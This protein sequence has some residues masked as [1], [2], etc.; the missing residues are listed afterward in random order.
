M[1]A[2][3]CALSM[4][5]LALP[6][7]GQGLNFQEDYDGQAVNT[8]PGA[9]WAIDPHMVDGGVWVD[10]AGRQRSAPY[11]LLINRELVMARGMDFSL[12]FLDVLGRGWMD[13]PAEAGRMLGDTGAS[14]VMQSALA[15]LRIGDFPMGDY[16]T[17]G[18]RASHRPPENKQLQSP[19]WW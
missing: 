13:D 19:G 4:L 3:I 7:A 16:V 1:R 6:A 14:L 15:G 5:A 12:L 2:L 17:H 8:P 10:D 9:P 18:G 11:S